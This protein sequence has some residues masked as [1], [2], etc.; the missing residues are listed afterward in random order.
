METL[1]E[2]Q[3]KN[4]LK[5]YHFLIGKLGITND[6]KMAILASYGVES[7]RDLSVGNLTDLCN[8][9]SLVMNPDAA[10]VDAWRKRAIASVGA[11]LR[12]VG[13][14]N[15]I[16]VIKAI[17]CRATGYETLN[18]IPKERLSNIYYAFLRKKNDFK[19]VCSI[20]REHI[21]STASLN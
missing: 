15:N 16:E 11:W 1:I 12:I 8:R 19:A 5:R 20:E 2:K 17:I 18:E 3:K 21:E 6:E 14:D 13:K 10:N 4:L 7:G 9:L